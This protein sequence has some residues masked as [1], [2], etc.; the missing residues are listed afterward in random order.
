MRIS[1]YTEKNKKKFSIKKEIALIFN[2]ITKLIFIYFVIQFLKNEK[3]KE[4]SGST[5]IIN[6]ADFID[7]IFAMT[8]ATLIWHL[9]KIFICL[10]ESP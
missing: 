2:D 1:N 6:F 10:D 9:I 7:A 5:N 8:I 4:I 3:S